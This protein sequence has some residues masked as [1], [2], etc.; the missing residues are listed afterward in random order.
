MRLPKEAGIDGVVIAAS[1]CRD[2]RFSKV[3]C[4]EIRLV[5]GQGVEND[6]HRGVIVQHLS[7]IAADPSQ[8]N[9]RQVHLLHSEL[10]GELAGMGFD[11]SPGD[12]GENITTSGID[13]LALPRGTLLHLGDHAQIEVTGLRNPCIQLDYFRPGLMSAVLGRASDGSLIRKA[14]IMA[15]VRAG[16][17]VRPGD[18]I[19][20]ELP[21]TPHVRLERV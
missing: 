17:V 13:L 8:P 2:H 18:M 20:V 1:A 7:R 10:F 4:P 9:L 11:I 5:A 19:R 15:I 3:S 12:I 16:G 6:A 21:A 14:G